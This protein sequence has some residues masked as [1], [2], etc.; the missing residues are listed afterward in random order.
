MIPYSNAS[1]QKDPEAVKL[2]PGQDGPICEFNQ[3]NA[4][5]RLTESLD[6]PELQ[7]GAPCSIQVFTSRMRDEECIKVAR[8]IDKCLK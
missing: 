2:Q 4:G 3:S 7:D 5:Y 6:D 8:V 1:K